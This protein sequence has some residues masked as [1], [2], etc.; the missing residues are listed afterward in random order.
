MQGNVKPSW[1]TVLLFHLR[2][3]S[4]K[5]HR[6]WSSC[7][8]RVPSDGSLEQCVGV[9]VKP[10]LLC[11]RNSFRKSEANAPCVLD[12]LRY[13]GSN[14]CLDGFHLAISRRPVQWCCTCNGVATARR[15]RMTRDYEKERERPERLSPNSE[16]R[17]SEAHEGQ[18]TLSIF[19]RNKT[20]PFRRVLQIKYHFWTT[21]IHI[22][23]S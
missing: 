11:Q 18:D 22:F 13:A 23:M 7:K 3:R 1:S 14:E 21:N 17:P 15:I 2:W 12:F 20:Q 19:W 9:V 16:T 4:K 5:I 8:G 6:G 10:S